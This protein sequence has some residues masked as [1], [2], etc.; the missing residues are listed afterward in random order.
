[1]N[2]NS[3]Q[4]KRSKTAK[5]GLLVAMDLKLSENFTQTLNFYK[6]DDP[7]LVVKKFCEENNQPNTI[8]PIIYNQL[9]VE[10]EAQDLT[11]QFS[12]QSI[13]SQKPKNFMS[14][15]SSRDFTRE[16][17]LLLDGNNS[18]PKITSPFYKNLLNREKEQQTG[19]QGSL[20]PPNPNSNINKELCQFELYRV[21]EDTTE[22]HPA[23]YFQKNRK[24]Q[25][26]NQITEEDSKATKYSSSQQNNNVQIYDNIED[27]KKNL[28]SKRNSRKQQS[29]FDVNRFDQYGLSVTESHLMLGGNNDSK[30]QSIAWSYIHQNDQK[31]S[32]QSKSGIEE[33]R[34]ESQDNDCNIISNECGNDGPSIEPSIKTLKRKNTYSLGDRHKMESQE[35]LNRDMNDSKDRRIKRSATQQNSIEDEMGGQGLAQKEFGNKSRCHDMAYSDVDSI[36]GDNKSIK[37]GISGVYENLYTSQPMPMN[38]DKNRKVEEYYSTNQNAYNEDV[39]M[40]Q[41]LGQKDSKTSNDN[42][43]PF[44]QLLNNKSKKSSN[45][46]G[47]NVSKSRNDSS[48]SKI[49]VVVNSPKSPPWDSRHS[50]STRIVFVYSKKSQEKY[51]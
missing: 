23:Q 20:Q 21:S 18:N 41:R 10:V 29:G 5:E 45:Q 9:M 38:F 4:S 31:A 12:T 17:M 33:P 47:S 28:L 39:I 19:T 26:S 34:N 49:K 6:D 13:Q 16:D 2:E 14:G 43:D 22:D 32:Q 15:N 44:A 40:N 7:Y 51:F 30:Y 37:F 11:Y 25:K 27:V 48:A 24:Y 50:S 42:S 8:Q 46:R 36:M 1:M 3:R 35:K